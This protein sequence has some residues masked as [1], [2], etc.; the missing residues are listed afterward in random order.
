MPST[1]Q[2]ITVPRSCEYKL[3][4]EPKTKIIYGG[5]YCFYIEG[6]QDYIQK[7]LIKVEY[8]LYTCIAIQSYLQEKYAANCKEVRTISGLAPAI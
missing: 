6:T 4:S 5:I 7:L 8:H 3:C 1:V 2:D